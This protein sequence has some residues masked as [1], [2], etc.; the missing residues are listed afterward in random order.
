MSHW[1][2]SWKYP[3]WKF[4]PRDILTE[5]KKQPRSTMCIMGKDPRKEKANQDPVVAVA[6]VVVAVAAVSMLENPPNQMEKVGK[7]HYP[8]TSVGDVAKEDTR[9]DIL[10]KLWKQFAEAVELRVTMRKCV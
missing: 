9:R 1:P 6:A 2:E 4:P 10:V 5:C 3:D 8:M 7:F